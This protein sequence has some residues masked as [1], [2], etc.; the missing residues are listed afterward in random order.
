MGIVRPTKA[1]AERGVEN[2][3]SLDQGFRTHG[4][5]VQGLPGLTQLHTTNADTT[6]TAP[7][8]NTDLL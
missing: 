5:K 1:L 4:R 8:E 6:H 2:G 7:K 3:T